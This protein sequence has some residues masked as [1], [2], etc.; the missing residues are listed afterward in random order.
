MTGDSSMTK[1]SSSY[2]LAS[3]LFLKA[4]GLI[5]FIAFLSLAVQVRGLIGADGILPAGDYLDAVR[6]QIGWRAFIRVPTIFWINASD[7]MLMG[8]CIAGAAAAVLLFLGVARRISTAILFVFY[9]SLVSVG[10]TFLSF[11]WDF[12]LLEA[13][14]LAIFLVNLGPRIWLFH[15]LLF[16]LVFFSGAVKLLSGD[17]SWRH[18]TALRYH[19]WTQPLPTPLAV[20]MARL[21]NWFQSVSVVVVFL[22]EIGVPFLIFLPRL[23]RHTAAY[24]IAGFQVLILLT[25]NYAFFNWLTIALC[26]LLLDDLLLERI[27]PRDFAARAARMFPVPSPS[28]LTRAMTIGL[29]SGVVL[30]SSL[31]ILQ[32]VVR[33]PAPAR[34]LLSWTEPFGV[35]NSYGLFAIMTTTRPE[36]IVEGSNDG[37][38]WLEY[39]FR[40][41]PDNLR[42]GPGWV[43]PY[44]PRLD[45]QMW[46]AAL[47]NYQQNPWFV[48]FMESLLRGSKPVLGLLKSDPFPNAPP[49]YIRALVYSYTFADRHDRRM[50]LAW[51][52][53]PV[54]TYFPAVSLRQQQ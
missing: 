12:L 47:S 9:L 46:F 1:E 21:P 45:W 2:T 10:S 28:A 31:E 17:P 18:L 34:S 7:A 22:V 41:K 5:Y 36:I 38:T 51:E 43:A 50:G 14:F 48:N 32:T 42:R 20:Y 33:L 11:Q 25:G 13:G 49:R 6:T 26:I 19:Y 27:L 54:A 29:V 40:F 4:L 52:R 39:R 15:W 8:V 24:V 44:Q 16:R 3:W 30:L 37:E 23:W 35:V 53:E